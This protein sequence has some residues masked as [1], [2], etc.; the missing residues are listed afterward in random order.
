MAPP[1]A[2]NRPSFRPPPDPRLVLRPALG[3]PSARALTAALALTLAAAL[4]ACDA[5]GPVNEPPPEP[6]AEPAALAAVLADDGDFGTFAELLASSAAGAINTDGLTVLAPDDEAF[7][8]LGPET[9]AGLRRQPATLQ[10]LLARHLVTARVDPAALADGDLLPTLEGTP[11]RVRIDDEG[12]V[13]LGEARLE[14]V[15]GQT[16]DGPVLRLSRVLRDH[17]TV[18]ERLAASPLLSPL[19]GL[20]PGRRRRPVAAGHLLRP[21]RRGL[22][23]GARR[24]GGVCGPGQP[25]ARGP[26]RSGRST[27]PAS[28]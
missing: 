26:G 17:L 21:P 1:P 14:G 19:A 28:R 6:P 2:P 23:P 16:P 12:T 13:F 20:L 4:A 5:V 27:S 15:V 3:L 11:I 7:A 9:V 18:A 22:R 24:G 10:R 8:R 25:R